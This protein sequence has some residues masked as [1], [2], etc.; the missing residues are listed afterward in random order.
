MSLT[1]NQ[2]LD[3][4]ESLANDYETCR[5]ILDKYEPMF[6]ALHDD[7]LV[8][9]QA[10]KFEEFTNSDNRDAL[11]LAVI[12]KLTI[13]EKEAIIRAENYELADKVK[14]AKAM[15]KRIERQ[16]EMWASQLSYHQ[17]SMKHERAISNYR[18]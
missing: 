12:S 13:D 18:A 17:S 10:K 15:M 9:I 16:H 8:N 1:P 3:K 14:R 6:D 4:M 2:L 11:E 5:Q 7:C